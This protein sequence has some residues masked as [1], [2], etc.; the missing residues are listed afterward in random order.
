L[1]EAIECK[2]RI[3]KKIDDIESIISNQVQISGVLKAKE[4]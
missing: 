1:E 3:K 2:T 4:K